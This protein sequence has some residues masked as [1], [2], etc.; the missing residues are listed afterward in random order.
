[1][2]QATKKYTY[3]FI[4]DNRDKSVTVL[5]IHNFP[6]VREET[7]TTLVVPNKVIVSTDPERKNSFESGPL[8]FIES[9]RILKKF[10]VDIGIL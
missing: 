3:H 1:M 4:C 5:K 7:V 9:W 6:V 10:L 2:E 8:R